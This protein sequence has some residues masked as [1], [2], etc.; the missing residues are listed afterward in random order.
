MEGYHKSESKIYDS[1]DELIETCLNNLSIFDSINNLYKNN[2]KS[3]HL[4]QNYTTQITNINFP[5]SAHSEISNINNQN[6]QNIFIT[7]P[8]LYPYQYQSFYVP[9]Y[10]HP[11]YFYQQNPYI[12]YN[13]SIKSDLSKNDNLAKS[14]INVQIAFYK[15][16]HLVEQ[17]KLS[18]LLKEKNNLSNYLI[19]PAGTKKIQK[20]LPN[21]S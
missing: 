15:Q 20:Y 9:I 3:T 6:N 7:N 21:A 19:K 1:D 12:N 16:N 14:K 8:C 10:Q 13:I 17:T 2:K 4:H 18:E 11:Q 5:H